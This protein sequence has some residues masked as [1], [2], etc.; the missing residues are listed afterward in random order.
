MPQDGGLADIRLEA[1]ARPASARFTVKHDGGVPP[2]AGTAPRATIEPAL[3]ED[4]RAHA[5]AEQRDDRVLRASTGAEPQLGL[6]HRLGA[7]VHED[8]RIE[9]LTQQSPKR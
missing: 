4:R 3:R 6:T 1:T 9:R 2:L 5:D 7:V 8:R